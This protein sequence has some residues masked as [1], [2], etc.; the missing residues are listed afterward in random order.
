MILFKA[1]AILASSIS[2][3]GKS[4]PSID[5][6]DFK[7]S[8]ESTISTSLI[9]DIS[10]EGKSEQEVAWVL[11]LIFQYE[12][13]DGLGN[14]PNWCSDIC[15]LRCTLCSQFVLHLS[16]QVALYS[17]AL[18]SNLCE[19]FNSS[20]ESTISTFLYPLHRLRRKLWTSTYLGLEPYLPASKGCWRRELVKMKVRSLQSLLVCPIILWRVSSTED[21]WFFGW[22]S[23]RASQILI[24]FLPFIYLHCG[25]MERLLDWRVPLMQFLRIRCWW[26]RIWICKNVSPIYHV[27]QMLGGPSLRLGT[28]KERLSIPSGIGWGGNDTGRLVTWEFP[29]RIDS[30]SWK[31]LESF[32]KIYFILQFLYSARKFQYSVLILD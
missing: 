2:K 10:F 31:S 32:I 24:F 15:S 5:R 23:R 30:A 27:S 3:F 4:L 25:W 20:N 14:F 16:R 19:D 13:D 6:E 1:E 8:T 29:L 18:E 28:P 22:R 7:S 12:N 11:T 26:W 17:S 21:G 9:H